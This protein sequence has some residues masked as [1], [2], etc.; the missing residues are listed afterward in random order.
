VSFNGKE[1][2]FVVP[3]VEPG[4]IRQI[5]ILYEEP[6]ENNLDTAAKSVQEHALKGKIEHIA[7][8]R[9]SLPEAA[10]LKVEYYDGQWNHYGSVDA[11]GNVTLTRHVQL[12]GDLVIMTA[13][14]SG[15]ALF[16]LPRVDQAEFGIGEE[17]YI[18]VMN[19][20]GAI[21][22]TLVCDSDFF[23]DKDIVKGLKICPSDRSRL[24]VAWAEV[25]LPDKHT[26]TLKVMPGT[27]SIYSIPGRRFP[28]GRLCFYH[29]IEL[30]KDITLDIPS[31]KD[32]HRAA[33]K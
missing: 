6:A 8:I 7:K 4:H 18:N 30:T 23:S 11:E 12:G 10:K 1:Q 3:E 27:Y 13:E 15:T 5:M 14:K 31:E 9:A 33:Q 32:K 2:S 21:T 22:V 16:Y 19:G 25:D 17:A 24:P 28:K 29:N 26:V 20:S